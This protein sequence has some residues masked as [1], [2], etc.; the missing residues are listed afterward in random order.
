[1]IDVCKTFLTAR[2]KEILMP[3]DLTPAYTD[4]NIFFGNMT[5]DWL[6]DHDYA[7][8]CL[9]LQ[10][11]KKKDGRLI[12]R[13]RNVDCT[14]YNFTRRRFKRTVLFRCLMYAAQFTDLWGS[15]GFTG[16]VD[17][18]EQKTTEASRVIADSNNRAVRI[19][20]HDAVRPWGGDEEKGRL[21][22]QP[23]MAI[24]RIEFTGGIYTTFSEP[25]PPSINIT[26]NY[27]T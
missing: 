6:K 13:E 8:N 4:S 11:R 26:P 3:D 14:Y 16:F 2:I 10:D 19:E 25:I 27:S 5:R 12:A 1:M 17:Q 20:L 9:M 23:R 18:F 21:K 7:V 15:T 22:R 24:S